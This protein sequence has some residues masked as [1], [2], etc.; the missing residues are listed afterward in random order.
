MTFI[1]KYI[2][3]LSHDRV[4]LYLDIRPGIIIFNTFLVITWTVAFGVS[5]SSVCKRFYLLSFVAVID[6]ITDCDCL[7]GQA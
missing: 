3:P 4:G 5:R 6:G 7:I 2:D 1:Y